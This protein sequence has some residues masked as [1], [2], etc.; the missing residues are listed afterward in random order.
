MST[1]LIA[2]HINGYE[3][4]IDYKFTFTEIDYALIYNESICAESWNIFDFLK[5]IYEK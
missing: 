1:V 2:I 3:L 5:T 4:V